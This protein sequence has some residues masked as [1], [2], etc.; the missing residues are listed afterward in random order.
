MKM[1]MNLLSV[2]CRPQVHKAYTHTHKFEGS[3]N[4]FNLTLPA[5]HYHPKLASGKMPNDD[6]SSG[7]QFLVSPCSDVSWA[8]DTPS[9]FKTAP[10]LANDRAPRLYSCR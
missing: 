1:G 7:L 8:H 5:T 4:T 3:D 2:V 10:P 9:F 6:L